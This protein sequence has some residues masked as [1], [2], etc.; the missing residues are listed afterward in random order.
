[1]AAK[2]FFQP[3]K[4]VNQAKPPQG[5]HLLGFSKNKANRDSFAYFPSQAEQSTNT[6]AV[7]ALHGAGGDAHQLFATLKGVAEKYGFLL[8]I[9]SSVGRTWDLFI[10]GFGPDISLLETC[11]H[12][13]ASMSPISEF[14]LVGYSDGASYAISV[15]LENSN[16]FRRVV[17]LSPGGTSTETRAKQ[18][19][20]FFVSH[21]KNDPVLN[22]DKCSRV[23]VPQLKEMGHNVEYVE[24]DGGHEVPPE[25]AEK[26]LNWLRL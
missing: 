1:M 23:I 18:P 11:M 4:P 6:V 13:V 8:I 7:I 5:L 15:G 22:I 16:L 25:I 20:S 3:Q 21:G 26:A 19:M 14:I 12:E 2:I 10:D 24:Y 17:A 9:P